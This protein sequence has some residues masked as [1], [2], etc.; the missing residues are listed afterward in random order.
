MLRARLTRWLESVWYGRVTPPWPLGV[1]EAVYL[2]GLWLRRWMYRKRFFRVGRPAAPVIVVGNLT[3][4]GTGKTPV[5]T[6]LAR[7]LA[8][9]GWRPGVALRGYRGRIQRATLVGADSRADE[10]GDEAVLQYKAASCPVAIGVDRVQAAELLIERAGCNVIICDD[11]LQHW[12]LRRDF[13]LVV[14]D[15]ERR[16]G[17]G[18]LLPAGPLREPLTRLALLDAVVVN[19][20]E[21]QAGELPL[22]VGG[23]QAMNLRVPGQLVA[24]S[25][26]RGLTVHAVA[27]IGN[28]QRFFRMLEALG[29]NVIAHPLPDHHAYRGNELE[30]ADQLPVL[31]TEKDAVKCAAFANERVYVVPV[32]AQ[33]PAQLA[34]RIHNALHQLPRIRS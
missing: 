13:E 1:L 33:L 6:W 24:L 5:V 8:Q 10:F 30:F 22:T 9:R 18:R 3:V 11:G 20:G 31:I 29:I 14:I 12:A 27:G 19:G 7:E 16:F 28:P 4:G 34:D 15:G 23:S 26:W 2:R 32:E 25:Q 17:N 21:P